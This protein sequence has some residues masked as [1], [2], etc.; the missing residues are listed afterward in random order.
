M[1]PGKYIDVMTD[2]SDP[3]ELTGKVRE[4]YLKL[5]WKNES[6]LKIGYVLVK[7]GKIVGSLV[8][9]IPGNSSI[10]GDE[11]FLE[12]FNAV[13]RTLIRAVEIYEADVEDI[14]MTHPKMQVTFV[15]VPSKS[16]RD[17]ESFLALLG[18]HN[19]GVEIQNGSKAWRIYVEN[20]LVKA[21]RAIKGSDYH[22]D[23]AIREILHET[24]HL[25]KDG[26][27][28]VGNPPEFSPEDTVHRADLLREGLELVREKKKVE[29]GF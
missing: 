21:A 25:L 1:L 2:F 11:A 27:Y 8:E 12:I 19:G 6:G 15:G 26:K 28:T 13:K 16:G 20:G 17:L 10:S 5:A 7:R 14:L 29:K 18:V 3:L 24:G 22:G 4:G 9:E 23:D